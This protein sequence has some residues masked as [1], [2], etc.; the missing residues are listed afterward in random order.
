MT[1]N[2]TSG[3]CETMLAVSMSQHQADEVLEMVHSPSFNE[4]S[5]LFDNCWYH[6]DRSANTSKED[7]RSGYIS[8]SNSPEQKVQNMEQGWNTVFAPYSVPFSPPLVHQDGNTGH[9]Q[10][11]ID[12]VANH[13]EPLRHVSPSGMCGTSLQLS[14]GQ[15]TTTRRHPRKQNRACDPCRSLKRAC[16]LS[17]NISIHKNKP[18]TACS[19]CIV[20]GVE[21]TVKWLASKRPVLQSFKQ[22]QTVPRPVHT[23]ASTDMRIENG[24]P[25]KVPNEHLVDVLM[26]ISTTEGD[27]ARQLTA[28]IT[29]S[30]QFCLYVDIFDMPISE[31][32]SE[33]SMPPSYSL[34]VAACTHLGHSTELS[35]YLEKANSWIKSCWQAKSDNPWCS[36]TAAPHLFRT[37]SILDALF[38]QKNKDMFRVSMAWRDASITETYQWVAMATAA[39]IAVGKADFM[40]HVDTSGTQSSSRDI[41]SATWRK[42]KDMVFGN[43]AAFSSFRHA[44]S[45]VLFG[46]ILPPLATDERHKTFEEDAKYA[47]CEGIRRLRTLCV[48]VR[49]C[50]L[51]NESAIAPTCQ[52]C[53]RKDGHKCLHA[54]D[55][56]SD[57]RQNI[58]EL[59]GAVEWVVTMFNA[60]QVATSYGRICAFTPKMLYEEARI[61]RV[62][63]RNADAVLTQED[64]QSEKDIENLILTRAKA[65]KHAFTAIWSQ[66]NRKDGTVLRAGRHLASLSIL[67]WKSLGRLTLAAEDAWTN[68]ADYREIHRHH[69]TTATLIQ[70]W[71]SNFGTFNKSTKLYLPQS[72]RQSWR[73]FAFCSNDTDLAILL[74]YEIA[75]RLQTRLAQHVPT[76]EMERLLHSLWASNAFHKEQRLLSA[77]Q[78]SIVASTCQSVTSIDRRRQME[79]TRLQDISAHP[80]SIV[81]R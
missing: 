44:L 62:S 2:D 27:L 34:G 55:V 76:L 22:V 53:F 69:D 49:A 32:L 9:S 46:I 6:E 29:C 17:P 60:V 31:C 38:G 72:Q 41:A 52:V 68:K 48:E 3:A 58:L 43:I 65:A 77:M 63:Q 45:L 33:G 5:Q 47:F 13:F 21:C 28:Q 24:T 18:S 66:G 67:I 15:V 64:P 80:V 78:V 71:R 75:Q 26:S 35:S 59:V 56:P 54:Q 36:A 50:F 42:A 10:G 12:Q 40:G 4:I 39:Q 51:E 23:E 7:F 70:L 20:R 30:Q 81:V 61:S 57:V 79:L 37:V 14:H 73:I 19:T 74:F 25:Q 8:L 11:N 1:N 16:N